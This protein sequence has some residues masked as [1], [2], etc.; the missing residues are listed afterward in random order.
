V[1]HVARRKKNPPLS[2]IVK[3]GSVENWDLFFQHYRWSRA[4]RE[5]LMRTALE[6]SGQSRERRRNVSRPTVKKN[7]GKE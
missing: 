7:A 1:I 3:S 4:W 5:Y 6:V 2:S